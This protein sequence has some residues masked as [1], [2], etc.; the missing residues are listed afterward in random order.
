M[1]LIVLPHLAHERVIV[2][3]A[4]ALSVVA[5]MWQA[6]FTLP[7]SCI[8]FGPSMFKRVVVSVD[9]Q[10]GTTSRFFSFRVITAE[11]GLAVEQ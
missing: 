10:H 11:Q 5:C 1:M 9:C 4:H 7:L 3:T 8:V 2:H 6:A